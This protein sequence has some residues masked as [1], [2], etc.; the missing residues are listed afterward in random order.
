M[1]RPFVVAIAI[2]LGSGLVRAGPLHDA[3]GAGNVEE[4]R[5]LI[6]EGADVNAPDPAVGMPLHAAA[7]KRQLE[8]TELLISEGAT[9]DAPAGILR[10]TPLHTAALV[11]G[12]DVATLLLANGADVNAEDAYRN[13]PLHVAAERGHNAI[14]ELLIRSGADLNARNHRND[15]AI[16]LAG[17]ADHFDTVDVL[18]AHGVTAPP[19]EA[20]TDLLRDADP[21]NGQRQ[22]VR[23]EGC[24]IIAKG[25]P[26]TYGPNLWGA[27][28]WGKAGSPTFDEYSGAFAR[29]EGSW[30]Y[31]D[32]NAFLANP[33]DVVPG[34]KMNFPGLK[35]P[36][37]RADMI[38]YLRENGETPP[39][40]PE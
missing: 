20:V 25:R 27:L 10:G 14:V 26:D 18:I 23:C 12:L 34:T 36:Q 9:I 37:E 22:F 32:M 2:V 40:L 19:V 3:A 5:R 39:P 31:E 15:T 8:V 16:R 24:H 33:E 29:L 1:R 28:E 38:V 4:V 35:K 21:R 17:K 30:S 6:V 7:S 13:T 11:G